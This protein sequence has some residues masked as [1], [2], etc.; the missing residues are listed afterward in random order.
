[1]RK[2]SLLEREDKD[3]EAHNNLGVTLCELGRL[4]EAL[5]S[6]SQA[7]SLNP[8]YAEPLVNLGIA[9]KNMRFKSSNSN[10]YPLSLIHI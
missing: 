5:S 3:A 2:M 9:I 6:Y 7:I 8:N 1:M 4:G 10:L